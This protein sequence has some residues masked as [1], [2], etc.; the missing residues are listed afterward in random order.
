MNPNDWMIHTF[1][2]IIAEAG[3]DGMAL[4]ESRE[5]TA[6]AYEHA[7]RSGELDRP[8]D[9]LYAE[10]L[11]VFDAAVKPRRKSRTTA[12]HRDA[13]IIIDALNDET[14]L[15]R[16]DP[17]LHVAYPLGTADGRDKTLT[18]W[19]A[20]DWSNAAITRYRNAAE[21]TASAQVFDEQAQTIAAALI[22]RGVGATTGDLFP[23]SQ[24]GASGGAS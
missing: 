7:V 13:T 5:Q 17:I 3:A 22:T 9:D 21:V 11:A 2:R 12:L 14:I 4:K 19:T 20:D 16:D 1:D 8:A 6:Q 10:G 15:G 23:D 18:R 24:G